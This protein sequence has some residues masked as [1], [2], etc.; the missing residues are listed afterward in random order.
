MLLF[1]TLSGIFLSILLLY[2]N[3]RN[4]SST[5][6]LGLFFLLLS[7]YGFIQYI[8]LYSGN[9]FLVSIF[10]I[11]F[12]FIMYLMGPLLYWY[13]R[14]ILTDTFN[15]R[16]YDNWHFVPSLIYLA[17]E[18]QYILT[19]HSYK[20]E[21]AA[22]IIANTDFV[23]L[24]RATY[25]HRLLPI[26][27]IFLS[28]PL[29]LLGYMIAS[30]FIFVKY[31][32]KRKSSFVFSHQFF[33]TN[34]LAVF[35]SFLF[36]LVLSHMASIIVS[37]KNEDKSVFYTL[38]LIQIFSG[39]GLTGLLCSPF[40]FPGILYGLPR[41]PEAIKENHTHQMNS[42]EPEAEMKRNAFN[43]EAGYL[44]SIGEKIESC[45][46]EHKPY[47]HPEFNLPQLSVLLRIPVHHLTY[48]FREERGQSFN[49]YRN[50]WRIKHSMS[51]IAEGKADGLTLEAIGLL[52]GFSTRNTFFKAFKKS[53]GISPGAFAD[54]IAR[55]SETKNLNVY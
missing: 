5:I 12:G 44:I 52:S 10:Y 37:F 50:E 15:L 22:Y 42:N 17:F 8:T 55:K 21:I 34:W 31:V 30:L 51:L 2:F 7:F 41:M 25:L 4:Y 39:V 3:A 35:F 46:L 40:F 11:N 36:L 9:L 23:A 48:Y 14:S 49:D 24:F 27:I 18:L 16:R 26:E 53:Q 54:Q 13:M 20:Q 28:R 43:L 32:S 1:L 38:N 47:L 29:L 6:Y 33:M 19:P 45:M